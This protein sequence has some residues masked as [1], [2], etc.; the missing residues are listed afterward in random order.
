MLFILIPTSIKHMHYIEQ[1]V[2]FCPSPLQ[3][4]TCWTSRNMCCFLSTLQTNICVTS[5]KC[6]FSFSPY[7]HCNQRYALHHTVFVILASNKNMRYIKQI[8]FSGSPHFNQTY[9]LHQTNVFF[10]LLIPTSI[11]NTCVTLGKRVV[12]IPDLIKHMR[13]IKQMCFLFLSSLK[14]NICVTSSIEVVFLLSQIQSDICVT[15]S[16]CVFHFESGAP[17]PS[18]S[19]EFANL[20]SENK[21]RPANNCAHVTVRSFVPGGIRLSFQ[22]LSPH[23]N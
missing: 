12:L 21:S 10:S 18:V 14:S 3:S 13:Y 9:A 22:K 4:N 7:P 6:V 1:Y 19:P 16:K 8:C 5:C 11:S 2:V 23:S 20:A 17:P 15:S